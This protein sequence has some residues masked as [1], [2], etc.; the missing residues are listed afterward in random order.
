AVLPATWSRGNPIDIIGDAPVER[1]TVALQALLAE[2]AAGAVL[3]MHAPTAIL[4]SAAI[5]TACAPLAAP[6]R[7][8]VMGCWLGDAAVAEA[9]ETFQH[10]GIADYATP[11]EAVRAALTSLGYRCAE[12][13]IGL[14]AA[15][16]LPPEAD[17]E[18]RV[19][20]ALAVLRRGVV[21][22]ETPS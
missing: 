22:K 18:S 14:S 20:A 17:T 19:R 15:A 5:A 2:P 1:Y 21:R 7:D 13:S 11:E 6:A 8:R 4:A 3:F 9:R 10:A 16:T 12:V